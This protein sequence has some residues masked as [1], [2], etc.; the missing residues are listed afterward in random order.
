M[1]KR[2]IPRLAVTGGIGSGKSTATAYLDVLGA[3]CI[4]TDVVVHVLLSRPEIVAELRRHFGDA[5]TSNETVDRP[6]LARIVFGDPEALDWLESLLH[7]HVKRLVNEWA[8]EQS[9]LPSPPALLVA[10]VPLL[11]ESEFDRDFDYVLLVTA[12]EDLRRRRLIDK[13]S[14]SEFARRSR[15]QLDE[16]AKAARS[17]FVVDNGGSRARLKE[18][19]AE[20]YAYIIA[21]TNERKSRPVVSGRGGG[22]AADR[23]RPRSVADERG[24]RPAAGRAS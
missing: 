8:T 2:D 21:A 7:P 18:A 16:K 22:S 15:R 20:V 9:R 17:D 10:E 3:S 1:V 19:V 5:V 11:F 14:A 12:P 13:M 6:A 24:S 23:R 4:S